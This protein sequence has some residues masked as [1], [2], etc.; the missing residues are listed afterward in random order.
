MTRTL[1]ATAIAAL[2]SAGCTSG[3]LGVQQ[4]PGGSAGIPASPIPVYAPMAAKPGGPLQPRPGGYKVDAIDFLLVPGQSM[5]YK[6]TL[7]KGATM[8]YSWKADGVI[9]FDFHTVPD[10]KPISASERFQA[11]EV[12]EAS[13][14]Y[15]APYPGLHG[16]W[17]ENSTDKDVMIRVNTAGFYTGATMFSDGEPTP[18]EV[19]DPPAPPEF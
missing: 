8:I 3:A 5:E 17:W 6:Y 9:K 1:I 12:M 16:W 11:A 13:G 15:V 4:T 10:G 19:A 18:M 7:D 14:V 2:A